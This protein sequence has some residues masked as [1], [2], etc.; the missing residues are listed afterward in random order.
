[1]NT[2][3][4]STMKTSEFIRNAVDAHLSTDGIDKIDPQVDAFICIALL[5]Y[6]HSIGCYSAICRPYDKAKEIIEQELLEY[7][8]QRRA[9]ITYTT[10]GSIL[11][12]ELSG[13]ELQAFRFMY[14]ELLAYYFESIG[15]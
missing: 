2:Q 1:M 6:K 13:E 5:Y 3:D 7:Q 10:I 15:D 4:V 11:E 12:R 8:Q 9:T 14:A